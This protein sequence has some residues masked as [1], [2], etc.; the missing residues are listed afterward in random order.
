[1]KR[2]VYT[3]FACVLVLLL[4]AQNS[5]HKKHIP[6]SSYCLKVKGDVQVLMQSGKEIKEDIKLKNGDR[7]SAEGRI[8]RTDGTEVKLKEN[9]CVTINGEVIK[10]K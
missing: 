8:R 1:M 2:S 10:P 5:K 3:L 9:E 6:D 7:I 4:P